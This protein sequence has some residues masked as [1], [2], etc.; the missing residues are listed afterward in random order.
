MCFGKFFIFGIA[1]A[2]KLCMMCYM[3]DFMCAC[4]M[5]FLVV[6]FSIDPNGTMVRDAAQRVRILAVVL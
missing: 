2:E 1:N 3:R 5:I 6:A 4:Q